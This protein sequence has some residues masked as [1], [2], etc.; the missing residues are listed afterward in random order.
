ME[1]VPELEIP[2]LKFY[3]LCLV[4]ENNQH[5][6]KIKVIRHKSKHNN[7]EKLT[8]KNEREMERN[9]TPEK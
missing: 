5:V 1:T 8:I 2:L 9:L 4:D 7:E 6:D 3:G